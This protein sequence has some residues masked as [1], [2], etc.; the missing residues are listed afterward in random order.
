MAVADVF[1]ALMC[2]RP[3]KE[4]LPPE[5]VRRQIAG[6]RGRHFDPDMV[7][8]FVAV[9]DDLETIAR[10]FSD[11]APADDIGTRDLVPPATSD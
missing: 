9:F 11:P 5:E 8:A 2:R 6:Q 7:D 3:Y 4:P 1:D 10:R